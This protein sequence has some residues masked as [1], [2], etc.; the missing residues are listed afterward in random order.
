[1]EVGVRAGTSTQG[2]GRPSSVPGGE[3]RVGPATRKQEESPTC[4]PLGGA[5]TELWA[6]A[7]V[8]SVTAGQHHSVTRPLCSEGPAAVSL[9][10]T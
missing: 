9:H 4:R 8:R 7:S 5:V 10:S 6:P 2:Q 3:G 1:M